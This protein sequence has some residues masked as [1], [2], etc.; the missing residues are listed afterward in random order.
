MK[1]VS[2]LFVQL[3]GALVLALLGACQSDGND[4]GVSDPLPGI[5]GAGSGAV[6]SPIILLGDINWDG[7][8]SRSD[9]RSLKA[10]VTDPDAQPSAAA[11]VAADINGDEWIS[12]EDVD[13]FLP[14]L[15][16][17][18]RGLSPAAPTHAT[19]EDFVSGDPDTVPITLWVD[20]ML[21]ANGHYDPRWIRVG[22][23]PKEPIDD[24]RWPRPSTPI[25]LNF[26]NQCRTPDGNFT[27]LL[28]RP[29]W[30][31]LDDPIVITVEL[32]EGLARAYPRTASSAGERTAPP[33]MGC[34]TAWK[35][36]MK[37]TNNATGPFFSCTTTW[38]ALS[39][40]NG[41]NFPVKSTAPGAGSR[42]LACKWHII[43]D[44]KGTLADWHRSCQLF[45]DLALPLPYHSK[46]ER[47]ATET[48]GGSPI[49]A[50]DHCCVGLFGRNDTDYQRPRCDQLSYDQCNWYWKD[51]Y[52]DVWGLTCD[53]IARAEVNGSFS[54]QCTKKAFFEI[55]EDN[56]VAGDLAQLESC[57]VIEAVYA[58]HTLTPWGMDEVTFQAC[59]WAPQCNQ[60][61]LRDR[62]CKTFSDMEDAL[63][64][65]RHFTNDF[66]DMDA[67]RPITVEWIA[68]KYVSGATRGS[69]SINQIVSTLTQSPRKLQIRINT[70]AQGVCSRHCPSL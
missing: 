47:G 41:L 57:N 27:R 42:R 3:S 60:F 19:D 55:N 58:G 51:C 37:T 18:P 12:A 39:A 15:K 36:H 56:F 29:P 34:P 62:G 46:C 40:T 38:C 9:H 30:A 6:S 35:K 63:N 11:L 48:D 54:S 70:P 4:T 17:L 43:G 16:G 5:A 7:R 52:Y 21:D 44:D 1:G 24:S 25:E 45:S 8:V 14:F 20:E 28:T 66:L 23:V 61:S 69:P 26:K 2:T 64:W 22:I 65:A 13:A 67:K 50:T 32:S 31:A 33:E 10:L 49:E 68:N 53:Y 59:A